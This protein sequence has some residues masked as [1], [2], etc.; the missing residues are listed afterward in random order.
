M[1]ACPITGETATR[2]QAVG[3]KLLRGL[4]RHSFGVTPSVLP[5]RGE[6]TLWRAPCGLMF[7]DP[8]VEG[9]AAFYA[10]LYEKLDAPALIRRAAPTR[11]EYLA[12]ARHLRAGDAVLDVGAGPGA[13]ASPGVRV[14]AL[15]PH[16]AEGGGVLRETAADHAARLGEHYDAVTAF[17]VI[18]HVADPLALTRAMLACL[19]P[20]GLLMLGA[21]LWPSPMTAIPNFCLNAPPH[22]LSWWNEGA[23]RAL[24]AQA[25]LVVRDVA[26]LPAAPGQP[27]IHWMG[28][29]APMKAPPD[30]PYFRADWR[31]HASLLAA[32][33]AARILAPLRRIP[34][35]AAPHFVLLVAQKPPR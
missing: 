28:R 21:P 20:G 15:D 32:Y 8:P 1:A 34:P 30:G 22:H 5:E 4:W 7:F 11:P 23:T 17:Q 19:K 16:A 25:G 27:L 26:L 6:F 31:W 29:L 35:D 33:A 9:D 12:A 24:A 13:F 2:V 14:T 3:T 18:E 10:A